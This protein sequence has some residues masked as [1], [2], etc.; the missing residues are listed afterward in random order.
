M[1]VIDQKND[2][3]LHMTVKAGN[4]KLTDLLVRNGASTDM[5]PEDLKK[6][7]REFIKSAPIYAVSQK[8]GQNLTNLFKLLPE[9]VNLKQNI[10]GD[11]PLHKSMVIGG[12]EPAKK[13]ISSGAQLDIQDVNGWTP[14]H[15]AC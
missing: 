11:T 14:L 9:E 3:V 1:A 13:L 2:S 15:K 12:I 10:Y 5:I 7:G 4:E 8:G 6:K